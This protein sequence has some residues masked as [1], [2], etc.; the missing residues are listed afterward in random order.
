MGA[1]VPTLGGGSQLTLLE[2]E[3]GGGLETKGRTGSSKVALVPSVALFVVA[4]TGAGD[5]GAGSSMANGGSMATRCGARVL[6]IL[7]GEGPN[8]DR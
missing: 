7:R 1:E 2:S 4:G 6:W 3:E 8:T 5:T